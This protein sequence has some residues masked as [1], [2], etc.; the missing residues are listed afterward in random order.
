MLIIRAYSYPWILLSKVKALIYLNQDLANNTTTCYLIEIEL[1][2]LYYCFGYP[3]VGCFY[4]VL[5][6]AGY[7]TNFEE[8]KYLTEYY[9]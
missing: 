8:L 9:K 2:R 4:K 3:L 7:K 1:R 5:E 6:H